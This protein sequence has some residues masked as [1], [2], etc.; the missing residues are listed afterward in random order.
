MIPVLYNKPEDCC[1]C[2]ACA[3]SCPKDAISFCSDEYGFLY[4]TIDEGKCIGCNLCV[5]SC[6]FTRIDEQARLPLEGY[7][8]RHKE[9]DVHSKSTS[10]GVFSALAEWII[11]RQ[12]IVYGCVFGDDF[13]PI[14]VGVDSLE[15][16]SAMRG[17][18]YA[19]SD[20]GVIYRDVKTKLSEGRYVLFTG[21]PCQVAGL[22]SYLGKSETS[23]LLTA[24]LICHGV[25]SAM[26]LKKYI[27][28]LE[29]KYHSKIES[30]KFR[31]KY[32][33]WTR[34]SVEVCFKNG[35]IDRRLTGR[36]IYYANFNNRN[37]QRPSCFRCKYSC[38]SRSG[39]ITIGDFWGFEKAHLNMSYKEGLSCCLL[40]TQKA[41]EVFSSLNL[42]VEKV[43]PN[44]II[45][46]NYHLRKPSTK[47]HDWDSVMNAIKR[48]GFG[49]L[50]V[51]YLFYKDICIGYLKKTIHRIKK[52]FRKGF[53]MKVYFKVKKGLRNSAFYLI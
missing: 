14:H 32:Y 28:Y 13:S 24:D 25:P 4:P 2:R 37:L 34:P 18:K 27:K 11:Q 51:S 49:S 3:N 22:Y 12:G 44:L 45:Q 39:D 20:T 31:S 48:T 38:S 50:T 43:D 1:G 40:N 30:L 42:A 5:K 46:G 10:G 52:H 16:I 6:V 15:G 8:A 23:K 21:T 17:S 29:K 41:V 33:G 47:G 7:A 35:K 53:L 36:S 9:H 26:S 19:Q